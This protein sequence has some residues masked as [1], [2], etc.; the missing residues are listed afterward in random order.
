MLSYTERNHGRHIE[1]ARN[2]A[3]PHEQ[4]LLEILRDEVENRKQNRLKKRIAEARF[5]YRK[6]LVDFDKGHLGKKLAAM[7]GSLQTLEFISNK[8]NVILIGNPGVGKSHLAIA[9]GIEAC[10]KDMRVLFTSVPNLVT[11][12]R[13]TMSLNQVSAF[14][15]KFEKY[16]LVILDELGYVS[17]DK[18]GCEMLFNLL[19]N[20]NNTGSIII[21]TNLVFERWDEIF[22]DP[23]LTGALIDRLAHKAHVADMSGDSYR[24]RETKDWLEKKGN[25]RNVK[26]DAS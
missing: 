14:G 21:T 1:E 18:E 15:K 26:T 17:F 20:R 7:V 12:L 6:Y 22:K 23:V 13:E 25:S 19:S 24:I 2:T 9:L 16:D 3:M 5:P 8:E 10:L 4:F 11:R